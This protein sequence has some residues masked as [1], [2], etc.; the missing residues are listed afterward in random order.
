MSE[1]VEREAIDMFKVWVSGKIYYNGRLK[2]A[3]KIGS[4]G[5]DQ[6]SRELCLPASTH[7]KSYLWPAFWP[8]AAGTQYSCDNSSGQEESSEYHS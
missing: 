7:L 5:V 8:G 1:S 2:N 4:R 6:M 3:N